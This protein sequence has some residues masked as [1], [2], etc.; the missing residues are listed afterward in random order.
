MKKRGYL[1]IEVVIY[2][3]ISVMFL[4]MLTW[5]FIPYLN[6]YRQEEENDSEYNYLL[7][8]Y[9]YM[10]KR[11]NEAKIK[12]LQFTNNEIYLYLDNRDNQIDVIKEYNGNLVVEYYKN[13]TRVK[14]NSLLKRVENFEVVEKE[15]LFYVFIKQSNQE[16]RVFCYEKK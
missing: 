2:L 14:Y 5:L 13:N 6:E 9:I 10:D 4:S 15:N 1:L 7:S 12:D 11:I 16:E 3:A 8:T